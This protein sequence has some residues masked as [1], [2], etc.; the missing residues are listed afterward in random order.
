[1]TT[2][3]LAP[4]LPPRALWE[5]LWTSLGQTP[6]AATR[7]DLSP[8]GR[9][10]AGSKLADGDEVREAQKGCGTRKGACTGRADRNPGRP[11]AFSGNRD[12]GKVCEGSVLRDA[13]RGRNALERGTSGRH[14]VV[15]AANPRPVATDSHGEQSLVVGSAMNHVWLSGYMGF[16]GNGR[17][18]AGAERRHGSVGREK[19]RRGEPHERYRS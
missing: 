13:T 16:A 7:P 17:K 3:Y 4:T 9:D 14:R 10:A 8:Q 19:P 11:A 18:A 1:M 12:R 5:S 15:A 2:R 6:G